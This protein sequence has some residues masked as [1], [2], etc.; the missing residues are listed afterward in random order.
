MAARTPNLTAFENL[1]G[2]EHVEPANAETLTSLYGPGAAHAKPAVA[3]VRP[4][5]VEQLQ[6]LIRLAREAGFS[7]WTR[8]NACGNGARFGNPAKPALVV[9][10]ERMNRI[11]EFDA[12]SATVL[13]EPGVTFDALRAY[14]NDKDLP[15]WCDPDANGAHSV[16]GSIT[17]RGFGYT[18]Y[19]DHLLMQ[20][21]MEV[22]LANGEVVRTGMGAIPGSNTWQLFKY[23]FG[24]YLDGL[25][26]RSN[27]ALVTKIGLWM[28]P[29]PPAFQPVVVA[30]P[31]TSAV[32]AA[33]EAL[34]PFKINMTMPNT[35]TIADT[36]ADTALLARGGIGDVASAGAGGPWR[37]F[38][39]LY[40][41]PAHMDTL[42]PA[43]QAA[44]API[45][46]ARML[47]EAALAQD[48]AATMRIGLMRGEPAFSRVEPE[49]MHSWLSVSAP[50]EGEAL[51]HITGLVDDALSPRAI[52]HALEFT[53]GWRTLFARVT[54][55]GAP[56]RYDSRRKAMLELAASLARAGYP[57]SHDSADLTG[58]VHDTQSGAGL[59]H[60]YSGLARALDPDQILSKG[61][62]IG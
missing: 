51:E 15:Y 3:R 28:M 33:V 48:R 11:I 20:C 21:G 52:E 10:L 22:V 32:A 56:G 42:L 9:E 29:A 12:Q 45:E 55:D 13:L 27:L 34:R 54:A 62:A 36:A 24:P 35:V 53:L 57:V 7:V 47:D 44:L 58:A 41:L 5:S 61:G 16:S 14:I 49:P 19:G 59:K 30:L 26:S 8:P 18:P 2:A 39:G 23:S 46:G 50:L 6:G 37:L 38:G 60:L 1:L 17:D 4:E 40:G 43:I 31:N 25:F